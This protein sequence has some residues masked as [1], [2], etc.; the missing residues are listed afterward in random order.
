MTSDL[1][2]QKF[3]ERLVREIAQR[4]WNQSDLAREAPKHLAKGSLTRDSVSNYVNGKSLPGPGFLRAI[5]LALNTS[6]EDLLPER[7]P[8]IPRD[9]GPIVPVDVRDA[10]GGYAFVRVNKR[11]RFATALKI[12]EAINDEIKLD[13]SEERIPDNG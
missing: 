6:P 12:M 4:N 8:Q 10:G 11:V 3:A 13:L 5:A 2:R 7:G 9:N 1:V